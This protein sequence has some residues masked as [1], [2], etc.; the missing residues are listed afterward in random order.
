VG[1][2][3]STEA[4]AFPKLEIIVIRDMPNWEEWS[5]VT[6]E[7]QQEAT[8]AGKKGREDEAAVN[9]KGEAPAPRMQLLPR[10]KELSLRG[11]PKLRTLPRQLGQEATNL[12]MLRLRY[13]HSLKVVENLRFLS[14]L[15][16]I[17]DCEGLERVSNLPQVRELR[18]QRCPNLRCV[19]RLDNLHQVFRTK[20]M[21]GVSSSHWLPGLQEQHRQLH[22]EDM[23]V[24]TG[25]W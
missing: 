9:Q 23:D 3:R 7:E 18:V 5:F 13:V 12:E 8:P 10:L 14:K 22:G 1:N 16:I 20:D 4:I 19:D 25:P 6:E 15:L 2:F 21:Q 24:Y 11:C 17:A